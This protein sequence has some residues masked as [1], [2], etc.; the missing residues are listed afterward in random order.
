[1]KQYLLKFII[2]IDSIFIFQE[3]VFAQSFTASDYAMTTSSGVTLEDM[4]S[5]TLTIYFQ[6][7]NSPPYLLDFGSGF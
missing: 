1:M 6:L 7:Y 4:S 5:A 2:A 3:T